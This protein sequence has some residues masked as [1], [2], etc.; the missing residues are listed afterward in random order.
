MQGFLQSQNVVHV[1]TT[2]L[3]KI[4]VIVESSVQIPPRPYFLEQI[5]N[6]AIFF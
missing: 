1:V 5:F 4:N 3:C 6:P 2:G